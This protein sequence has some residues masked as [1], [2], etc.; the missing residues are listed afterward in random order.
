MMRAGVGGLALLLIGGVWFYLSQIRSWG[1]YRAKNSEIARRLFEL[2]D[3]VP[4]GIDPQSWENLT[5][6]TDIGFGNVF[7]S[8]QHASYTEMLRFQADLEER[9]RRDKPIRVETLRWI[10]KRLAETGP[11]GKDYSERMVLLF[12]EGA[13]QVADRKG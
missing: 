7:F 13:A 9:L 11:H 4:A 10:W 3:Q 2:K 8:P 12:E 1:Q 5:T 6:L